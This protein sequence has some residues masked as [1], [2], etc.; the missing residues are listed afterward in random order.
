MWF[1]LNRNRNFSHRKYKVHPI[2]RKQSELGEFYHLYKELR[3]H[4]DRYDEWSL[5]P[6]II[7]WGKIQTKLVKQWKNCHKDPIYAEEKLM[8]TIK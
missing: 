2:N 3:N 4:P 1:I 5:S 8:I 6:L 7:F